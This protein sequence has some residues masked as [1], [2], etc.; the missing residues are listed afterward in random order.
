VPGT[1]EGCIFC[2][3]CAKRCFFGAIAVDTK[4]RQWQVNPQNC[5]GCGVCAIGCKEG[6]L[7]LRRLERSTP[8]KTPQDLYR[9]IEIDNRYLG[10]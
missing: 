2:G 4:A 5:I 7:K 8:F 1:N 9:Q 10:G 6:A 3:K